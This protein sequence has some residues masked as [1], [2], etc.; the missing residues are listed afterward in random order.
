MMGYRC[1]GSHDGDGGEDKAPL[2]FSIL[3]HWPVYMFTP[4][5]L[6]SGH[7]YI[8]EIGPRVLVTLSIRDLV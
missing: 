6:Y 3:S 4:E 1:S 5:L 7:E 8:L 2:G